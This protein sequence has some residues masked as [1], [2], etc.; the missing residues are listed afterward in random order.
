MSTPSPLPWGETDRVRGKAGSA[1]HRFH[2]WNVTPKQ[3]VRIQ[4]R[5]RTQV[6]A[7]G[8][9]RPV[10]V[11]GADL[12]FL[13]D[14][15]RVIAAVVL[16]AYPSM[17]TLETV[18]RADRTSFP[19]VP[20]LLSFRESPPLLRALRKLGRAPDL[21]FIDGHGL[22]HPRAAGIA[23]HIGVLLDIPVIGCAKSLL[24]GR[25][26]EPAQRAGGVSHLYDREGSVIGAAVRTRA[27]VRPV[28]VS[29]GHR[30][31]LARAIRLTLRCAKGFRI[32]EPTRQAHLAAEREKRR[33]QRGSKRAVKKRSVGGS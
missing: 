6:V 14:S 3:A 7:S 21:L 11:A 16:L 28:F 29:V 9:V 30:I 32:P 15:D 2:A 20:G 1:I 24:C 12:A 17:E 19:Y 23:C 33:V 27:G 25:F 26:T 5:L 18:V 4:Q 13:P 22:S 31:G 8:R 10:R